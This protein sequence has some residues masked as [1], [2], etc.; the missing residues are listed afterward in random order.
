MAT[1]KRAQ[2]DR[3]VD[4][5]T[6]DESELRERGVSLLIETLIDLPV[7]FW[8]DVE[9]SRGL[10]L[11]SLTGEAS[12]RSI[13]RHI[14]PGW[15]RHV[16]RC[17]ATGDTLGAAVPEDVRIRIAQLIAEYRPPR[18]KWAKDAVDPALVRQLLAPVL[19][20]LLLNFARRLPIPGLTGGDAPERRDEGRAGL[21]SRLKAKVEKRAER[22][23][24]AGKNVLGGLS[25]EV[26][27][28]IQSAAREF[29]QSANREL[30]SAFVSRLRSDEGR[31]LLDQMA[32]QLLDRLLETP[33]SELNA[34]VDDL[35][36]DDI[37]ALVPPIIEHNHERPEIIEAVEEELGALLET[38]GER[39]V[40]ELLDE[41]GI[42]DASLATALAHGD[43]VARE[44][45]A[46]KA[47]GRWL[48]DVLAV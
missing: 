44:L 45:F 31:E 33:L 12:A 26:E 48:D 16:A 7:S 37:W 17:E 22:F 40:R 11:D 1:K 5:L 47:F 34:D 35:P 29:S 39:S 25:A 10:L 28:Q 30:R 42:L 32:N 14:R 20:D 3:I 23:V 41:A 4:A 19:Q 27:R 38:E 18:S 46:D 2:R 8:I 6:A 36:W 43:G 13:E 9:E 15:D 21:R 24:E